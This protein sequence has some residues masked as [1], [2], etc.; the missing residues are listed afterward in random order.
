MTAAARVSQ[1]DMERACKAVKAAG[2]TYARIVI[3]LRAQRIEIFTGEKADCASP[4][5]P[6]DAE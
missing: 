3:D 5:N 2:F 4:L 6:W 1:A